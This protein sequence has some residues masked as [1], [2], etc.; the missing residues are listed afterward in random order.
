M[1]FVSA[2]MLVFTN[3]SF[4]S[5]Y[6]VTMQFDMVELKITNMIFIWYLSSFILSVFDALSMETT[7]WAAQ[8]KKID[9]I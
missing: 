3:Y 4:N 2:V 1:L 9:R 6:E 8:S 5:M 7:N